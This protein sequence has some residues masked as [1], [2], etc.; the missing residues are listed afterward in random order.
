[1]GYKF[2]VEPLGPELPDDGTFESTPLPAPPLPVDLNATTALALAQT[3]LAT[4]SDLS[5]EYGL[6]GGAFDA[7]NMQL[8]NPSGEDDWF[9]PY[10][11]GGVYTGVFMLS[12]HFGILEEAGW[13]ELGDTP[14]SLADLVQE[15]Q[16]IEDGFHPDDNP[17]DV[18]EA[19]TLALAAIGSVIVGGKRRRRTA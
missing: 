10:E 1:V 12:A 17:V 7:A 5:T 14:T 9:I 11:R 15:Y 16:G 4:D 8:M 2:V 3:T 18:P 6:S 13:D 19:S